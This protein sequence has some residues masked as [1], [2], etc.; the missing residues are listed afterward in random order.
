MAPARKPTT[1]QRDARELARTPPADPYRGT[2]TDPF[3]R[4]V[5]EPAREPVPER[6][7]PVP[8]PS[9][10]TPSGASLA[11]IIGIALGLT[12]GLFGLLLLTI[13]SLQNDYGAPDRSFYRGTDSGYVVLGLVNFVLAGCCAI[14]GIVLMTGRLSGRIALTIGGWATILLSGFWL[15]DGSVRVVVPIVL[16][17]AAATMLCFGYQRPVTDWLGVLPPPQPE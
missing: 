10:R 4:P 15:I 3:S 2:L 8:R 12:L 7:D 17:V 5:A 16:A 1:Q 11:G 13:V 9:A 6:A 14:G